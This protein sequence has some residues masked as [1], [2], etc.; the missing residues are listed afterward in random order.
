MDGKDMIAVSQ[1]HG[2]KLEEEFRSFQ[3]VSFSAPGAMSGIGISRGGEKGGK[4]WPWPS[5]V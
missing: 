1:I 3:A 4:S 5:Y 2:C